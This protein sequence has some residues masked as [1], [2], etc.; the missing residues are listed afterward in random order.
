MKD[1]RRS[2]RV[3]VRKHTC[4]CMATIYELCYAGGLLFIRRTIRELD[5]RVAHETDRLITVRMEDLW[6][7]LIL[8]QAR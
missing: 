4:D 3:R 1:T 2:D 8:G 7:R 5:S 6:M